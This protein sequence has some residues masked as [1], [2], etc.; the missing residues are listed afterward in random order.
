MGNVI[1]RGWSGK[2]NGLLTMKF[3]F[4]KTL[5]TNGASFFQFI[6]EKRRL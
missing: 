3:S 1:K 4:A 5:T 2:R 6:T